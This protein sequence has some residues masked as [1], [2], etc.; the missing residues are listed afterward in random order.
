MFRG[1]LSKKWCHTR[2]PQSFEMSVNIYQWAW[3]NILDKSSATLPSETQISHSDKQP[4]TLCYRV[5]K[6]IKNHLKWFVYKFKY[7]VTWYTMGQGQ[8]EQSLDTFFEKYVLQIKGYD[9]DHS[10]LVW[11][12]DYQTTIN[13]TEVTNKMQ[14]CTRIYYSSVCQLLNMFWVTHRSSSGAQKL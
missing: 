10:H 5:I 6:Q 4:K 9:T 8:F 2:A 13:H 12:F 3:D 1:K 14:P 7:G 11:T